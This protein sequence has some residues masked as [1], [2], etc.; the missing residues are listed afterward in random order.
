MR[1]RVRRRS[2]RAER[3]AA[4]RAEYLQSSLGDRRSHHATSRLCDQPAEAQAGEEPFGWAKTIGGLA[5][6]MLR[7]RTLGIQVHADDGRLRCD[8]VAQL[9]RLARKTS[10]RSSMGNGGHHRPVG[11]SSVAC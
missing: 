3:D 10:G 1:A 6:P 2:A 5:R 7:G 11:T 8:P 4:R 9:A